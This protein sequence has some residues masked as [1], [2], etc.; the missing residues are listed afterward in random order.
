[1]FLGEALCLLP[2]ALRRWYKAH[3]AKHSSAPPPSPEE[4]AAARH[5]LRR[6]FIVF[7]LPALCDAAA[8]TMLN[9][10]LFYT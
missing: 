9:L 2:F 7:S 1:M 5:R 8:T 4:A 6:S 3:Q 10:G